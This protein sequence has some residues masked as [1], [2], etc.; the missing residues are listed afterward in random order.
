MK[1]TTTQPANVCSVLSTALEIVVSQTSTAHPTIGQLFALTRLGEGNCYKVDGRCT[2]TLC[3]R[4]RC[5]ARE[6]MTVGC[7]PTITK[8]HVH[9]FLN[10]YTL[11]EELPD[12]VW[13]H[14]AREAKLP[15]HRQIS[16]II[17]WAATPGNRCLALRPRARQSLARQSRSICAAR[18][19]R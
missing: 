12:F 5:G 13:P 19:K 17:E 6:A 18:A 4:S 1:Q 14:A 8:L 3:S 11:L 7:K 16:M 2:S 15:P 9:D 10:H